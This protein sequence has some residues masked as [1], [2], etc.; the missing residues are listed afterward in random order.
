MMLPGVEANTGPDDFFPIEQMQLMRFDG[1]SW[2]LFG[3][4]ITG[5]VG[6]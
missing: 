5:E 4:V 3:E 2:R 6:H 1:E